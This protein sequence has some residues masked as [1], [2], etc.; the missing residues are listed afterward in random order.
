MS[1]VTTCNPATQIYAEYRTCLTGPCARLKLAC[2]SECPEANPTDPKAKK[3]CRLN[4]KSPTCKTECK[5]RKPNCNAPGAACLDPRFIGADGVPPVKVER[6]R[7]SNSNIIIYVQIETRLFRALLTIS[8]KCTRHKIAEVLIDREHPSYVEVHV[9]YFCIFHYIGG[10]INPIWC[11]FSGESRAVHMEI[12]GVILPNSSQSII[13]SS[14]Q[15]ASAFNRKTVSN[16]SAERPLTE[17]DGFIA[18]AWSGSTPSGTETTSIALTNATELFEGMKER[19]K[20]SEVTLT[21]YS[22]NI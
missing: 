4:C 9:G 1:G 12:F 5:N 18:T 17:E 10:G 13:F 7:L 21:A 11:Y 22:L 14:D 3:A 2:P 8:Q 15:R 16:A 20:V 6:S 19:V